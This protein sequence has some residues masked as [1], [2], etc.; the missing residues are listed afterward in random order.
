MSGFPKSIT[1]I[2]FV[3]YVAVVDLSSILNKIE[4][5]V[6]LSYAQDIQESWGASCA[7]SVF[8]SC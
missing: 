4:M 3:E 7:L 5:P 2:R 6:R 8:S 1:K